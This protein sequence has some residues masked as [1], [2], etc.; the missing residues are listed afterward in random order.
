[1]VTFEDWKAIDAAEVQRGSILGKPR[2][3]FARIAGMLSA[4]FKK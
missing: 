2:E 3:K 1:M 4:I